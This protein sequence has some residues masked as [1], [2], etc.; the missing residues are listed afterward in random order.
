MRLILV[1]AMFYD[2]LWAQQAEQEQ[3]EETIRVTASRAGDAVEAGPHSGIELDLEPG[4]VGSA[5]SLDTVL[6]TIPGVVVRNRHN[7]SQG[8][9]ITIRGTGTRAQFGV[10]GI[11]LLMDGIPLTMPDGQSQTN[12]LDLTAVGRIHVLR[13]PASSLYGN[14]SGGVIELFTDL[15][16]DRLT[17]TPE[18][19]GGSDEIR[20][21][22]LDV[23][24]RT[25]DLRFRL[26]GTRHQEKGFRDHSQARFDRFNL[27]ANRTLGPGWSLSLAANHFSAPYMLNPSSLTKQDAETRPEY[28]RP[29]IFARGAAKKVD[30]TQ[31]GLTLRAKTPTLTW[32]TTLYAVSRNLANPIPSS[33]IDLD[34]KASG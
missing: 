24:G 30:Q 14:A 8:D 2:P 3:V 13:G 15:G 10:R 11:K 31:A 29:F 4:S 27:V 20:S 19:L 22:R 23:A 1:F 18:F 5:L 21:Q 33:I 32:Q 9:R 16:A 6:T 25:G 28:V 34:R 7:L 26:N 12:N 17:V